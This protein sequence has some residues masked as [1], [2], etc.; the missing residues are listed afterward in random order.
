MGA[1]LPDIEPILNTSLLS[2]TNQ[3]AEPPVGN[4]S[5]QGG[6]RLPTI[7]LKPFDGKFEEWAEFI[8]LFLALMKKFNGDEVEKLSHL[9]NHL[10]DEA[11]DV[12]RHL[13]LQNGNYDSAI[14]LLRSHYENTSAI[15]DSH[16]K[17]FMDLAPMTHTSATSLRVAVTTTQSCLAAIASLEIMTET[18]DP[19]VVYVLKNKLDMNLRD[20]WEEERKGSHTPAT[21]K[22]FLE[23]LQTRQRVIASM[24]VASTKPSFA[25]AA[26]TLTTVNR[27]RTG[28][29]KCLICQKDHRVF[30]CPELTAD[31]SRAYELVRAKGLCTNCL[32][33]HNTSDCKSLGTCR[34]CKQKHHS[35]LHD[36]LLRIPQ[37]NHAS[38]YT[39]T[40]LATAT[41]PIHHNGSVTYLR[42]LLDQ[43][44]TINFLSEKAAY[45]LQCTREKIDIP[46]FGLSNTSLGDLQARTQVQMG[47]LYCKN[48][49]LDIETYITDTITSLPSVTKTSLANWPH[50]KGLHLADP[51][52]PNNE[53]IDLLIGA[54]IFAQLLQHG[55]II[56]RQGGPIAQKTKLGW[57]VSGA[58]E[59]FARIQNH[60]ITNELISKQ[61]RAFWEIEENDAS[62]LTSIDDKY[63]EKYFVD[64][65]TRSDDGKLIVRIPFN[66]DPNASDFLGESFE[67]A[68]KRFLHLERKF[69]MNP[70]LKEEYVKGINEYIE[71]GHAVETKALCHVIP[72]LAVIRESSLTTKVRTVYDASAFTS[73][74]FSLNARM[75]IGPALLADLWTVY[76]R[77]RVGEYAITSD[78]E[79]MYRQFWVHSDD[80]KFQQILWRES[81]ELELKILELK[82]V[83]FGTAAAPFLAIRCLHWIADSVIDEHPHLAAI[84]KNNFYMDDVLAS[85]NDVEEAQRTK[86]LLNEIFGHFSL[87]L[88]KWNSNELKLAEE[89]TADGIVELN[90]KPSN[91]CSILGM[92]WNTTTD[93][94]SYSLESKPALEIYTNRKILSEIA[95]F[96]DP[97]GLLAPILFRAKLLMQQL[98]LVSTGWDDS[99][100]ES[101]RTEWLKL[102]QEI[103]QCPSI[104]IDRW[105]GYTK[106]NVGV[107]IHG[108]ADASEKGYAAVIYVRTELLDGTVQVN[109]L[110]S[111]TKIAPLKVISIPRLEL[112]AATLT[113]S[114]LVKVRDALNLPNASVHAWTDSAICLAWI[115]TQPF[116]LKTFVANRVSQIQSH[117]ESNQWHHVRS[118]LNPADHASRGLSVEE[119]VACDQ[120]W[121]GPP[122]LKEAEIDWPKT[123]IE[124]LPTKNLSELKTN[125]TFVI[126]E[127]SDAN[128]FI[129]RFS[130]YTVLL[131]VTAICLRWLPG[132]KQSRI[133]VVT[134]KELLNARNKLLHIVQNH[135]YSDE[136][137]CLGK[138]ETLKK[139][140]ALLSL[141]PFVDERGVLRV[142]GR[143]KNS[144]LSDEGKHPAIIPAKNHLTT[145][146]VRHSHFRMLHGTN[147]QTLR[148]IRDEFWIIRGKTVVKNI[149][150]KCI[151]CFRT[152]CQPMKQQMSDL[153]SP[154]VRQ[155]RPFSCTGVDYAGHFMVKSSTLRNAPYQK[156]YVSLFVCLTTKAIHLELVPNLSTEA[157][158]LALRRFIA[159]RG[160]PDHMYSDQGSNFIGAANELPSLLRSERSDE[161]K[162]IARECA[163]SKITWHFTPGRAAHF[164]GLWEAGVKSMKTHIYRCFDTT[165][166]NN[167]EFSTALAQIEACLNSRPLCP[168][169]DDPD[170]LLVLTPGHFLTGQALTTLPHPDVRHIAMGRLSRFQLIQKIVQDFWHNWSGEYLARLQQRPKWKKPHENVQVG[171]LVLLMEDN[172]P[173][174]QWNL[175][176]IVKVFPGKDG[177]IRCVEVA[178]SENHKKVIISR[179]INKICL[180]PVENCSETEK[181][182]INYSQLEKCA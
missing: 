45:L 135:E 177:L 60:M 125:K 89:T 163:N 74:G 104:T 1:L 122:F 85:F 75:H 67:Q 98:W 84:I 39:N 133:K 61:I 148:A 41:V 152:R 78:I 134:P 33:K 142:G 14:S 23:F 83:T 146:I 172:I 79:K 94:L 53:Q 69:A 155:H 166:L 164:G 143:L 92:K 144:G 150:R 80:S 20:K 126:Y 174:S 72:H 65:T 31:S 38:D 25:K 91:T 170:D 19:F 108:F 175:A 40:L 4:N 180:L 35:L 73:N 176:R 158:I 120:W 63:C 115:S 128:D 52:Q 160:M 139:S 77:W 43:G 34:I 178:K 81:P 97:L 70:K 154:Q 182:I 159:R 123:P 17:T 173:P 59:N 136:I 56:G 137:S 90:L 156:C 29:E 101:I 127:K 118:K 110:T 168:I 161:S 111:K 58:G 7:Q 103:H 105:I 87:N 131:R 169:N 99:V 26:K 165:K 147:Q 44:S 11:L 102:R 157:F 27:I 21:L 2:S 32:Y 140:S 151:T 28:Q 153:L 54:R 5:S 47:S 130:S 95:S 16:L 66:H 113:A 179:P 112:C 119:C 50:L 117:V 46:V 132:N 12:I 64:T 48:F 36:A 129:D 15:I 10:R 24:P 68:K 86:D 55:L 13:P 8:D 162:A 6:T 3:F 114:L 49:R 42:A 93:K 167:E 96:F 22:E 106:N 145:L 138:S 100:P 51:A 9:R 149:L 116:R 181:Q 30:M 124:M 109:L 62:K 121:H 37:V 82:T 57:I 71:L 171:Q 141:N 88:R 107:S 76:L 18:W